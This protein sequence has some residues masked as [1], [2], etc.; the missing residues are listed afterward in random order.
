MIIKTYFEEITVL[1]IILFVGI[2]SIILTSSFSSDE[3]EKECVEFY[4]E[5]NYVLDSCECYKDELE[6]LKK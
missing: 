3:K 5:N 2:C 6:A 1:L 4:L